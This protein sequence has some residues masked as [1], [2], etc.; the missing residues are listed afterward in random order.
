MPSREIVVLVGD[1][2][3]DWDG[4]E[5][6]GGGEEGEGDSDCKGG[7]VVGCGDGWLMQ[8]MKSTIT[9][10]IRNVDMNLFCHEYINVF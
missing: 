3:I 7:E 6:S 9:K 8:P 4:K 10:R 5:D 1:S 2:E